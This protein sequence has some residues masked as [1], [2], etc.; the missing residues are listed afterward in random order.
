MT[1]DWVLWTVQY[2]WWVSFE[3]TSGDKNSNTRAGAERER[4]HGWA[5]GALVSRVVT[6]EWIEA[7]I[8]QQTGAGTQQLRP[9]EAAVTCCGGWWPL[10]GP[11]SLC[12]RWSQLSAHLS[13]CTSLSWPVLR[14]VSC[15]DSSVASQ[16][17]ECEVR[18]RVT[19]EC[20]ETQREGEDCTLG[21]RDILHRRRKALIGLE[22]KLFSAPL[23]TQRQESQDNPKAAA[24]LSSGSHYVRICDSHNLKQSEYCQESTPNT[25]SRKL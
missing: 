2:G 11:A 1:F 8:L 15:E 18:V 13:L 10:Y 6:P 25:K 17:A 3:N 16:S 14:P 4:D 20:A 22:S 5:P 21:H 24:Q 12:P 19:A 23:F 7:S 9:A